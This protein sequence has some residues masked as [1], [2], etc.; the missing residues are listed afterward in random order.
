M[1]ATA[2]P[3]ADKR[4]RAAPTMPACDYSPRPYKGPSRE[5]VIAMRKQF[6]NPAIFTIYKEPIMIGSL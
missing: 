5:D 1:S 6:A 4:R 3:A 2:M